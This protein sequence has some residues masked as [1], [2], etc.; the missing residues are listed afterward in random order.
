MKD[1]TIRVIAAIIL[2]VLMMQ[3]CSAN[4]GVGVG[5]GKIAVEEPL[6]PGGTYKINPIVVLNTGDEAGNYAVDV[7]YLYGQA[8]QRPQEEW[9]G[10]NPKTFHLNPEETQTVAVTLTVPL[11]AEPGDYFCFLEAHPVSEG[12][13]F[14]IGVA[15]A[16]KLYFSVKPANILSA[17]AH[18]VS[19]F[20]RETAPVSYIIII[21]IL[22]LVALLV[23]RKHISIEVRRK[24]KPPEGGGS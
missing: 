14:R 15:A 16:T 18:K 12:E 21:A 19:S 3:P 6:M 1:R 10:F 2:V 17:L 24:K 22:A 9:V 8:E 5:T 23:L 11:D 7:T 20:L 4:V 13:G